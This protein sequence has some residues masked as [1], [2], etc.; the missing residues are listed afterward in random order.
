MSIVASFKE[1]VS[2]KMKLYCAKSSGF[3]DWGVCMSDV[4]VGN[5]V[6][7]MMHDEKWTKMIANNVHKMNNSYRRIIEKFWEI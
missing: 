3:N 4:V 1:S 2:V 6:W 7:W 5:L